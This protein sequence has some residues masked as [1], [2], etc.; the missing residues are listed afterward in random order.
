MSV[1]PRDTN[2]H[3]TH[4]ASIAAGN[5]VSMASMLGF[6]QGTTRGGASSARIAV[7][8]VCWSSGCDDMDILAAFDDAIADGVDI[9]SFSLGRKIT[10]DTHFSDALSIGAFHAMKNGILTVCAAGNSGPNHASVMNVAPWAISVAASTLDRKFVTQVKLGNN[11]FFE[12]NH[13]FYSMIDNH[14]FMIFL[15]QWNK[16]HSSLCFLNLNKNNLVWKLMI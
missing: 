6:G 15:I 10:A 4:I 16:S 1:S 12:V 13:Y 11:K 8:K 3:G 2:G 14:F 7:Y 9:I 5:P